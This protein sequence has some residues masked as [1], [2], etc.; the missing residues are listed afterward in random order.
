MTRMKNLLVPFVTFTVSLL[1]AVLFAVPAAALEVWRE[2]NIKNGWQIWIEA[3]DYD[4]LT[5]DNLT[6][7]GDAGLLEE[8]KAWFDENDPFLG[9]DI[10]ISRGGATGHLK[11]EFE[12]PPGG[13]VEVSFYARVQSTYD[14]QGGGIGTQS[15]FLGLNVEDTVNMMILDAPG[16]WS[17][18]TDRGATPPK[19]ELQPGKNFIMVIPREWEPNRDPAIDV[20]MVSDVDYVPTDDDFLAA[21]P[22][23]EAVQP[24]GKL[25]TM[26]G[27]VKSGF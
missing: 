10:V 1:L 15:W 21:K 18:N 5:G 20:I 14:L 3:K 12:S 16:Q 6:T 22:A 25:T 4:E 8:W 9:E 11:Y 17:W 2:S 19:E 23:V 27:A 13:A 24:G 7:L 26:W